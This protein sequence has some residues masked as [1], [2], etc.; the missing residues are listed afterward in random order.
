MPIYIIYVHTC[1][2]F[3]LRLLYKIMGFSVASSLICIKLCSHC[4]PPPLFA[5]APSHLQLGPLLSTQSPICFLITCVALSS[6]FPTV[7][8]IHF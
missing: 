6:L 8:A 1:Y 7:L 3:I 5:P 4:S 2:I